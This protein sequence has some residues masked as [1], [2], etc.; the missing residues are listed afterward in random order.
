M[1]SI[2]RFYFISEIESTELNLFLLFPYFFSGSHHLRGKIPFLLECGHPICEICVKR[3][4]SRTCEICKSKSE[5]FSVEQGNVSVNL[6]LMGLINASQSVLVN[7]IES[8]IKFQLPE[9]SRLKKNS[10][11]DLGSSINLETFSLNFK[12]H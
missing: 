3:S 11:E 10:S 5:Q 9:S 2:H 8:D 7:S 12:I 4:T 1:N 6:Y